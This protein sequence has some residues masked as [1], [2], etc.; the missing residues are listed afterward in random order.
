MRELNL[1]DLAQDIKVSFRSLRRVPVLTLTIVGT[2]GLGIG[3]TATIFSAVNAALLRPLPY[4]APER[5][6]GRAHV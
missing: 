5:Q 3:A 4:A 1:H 6:I 2:V